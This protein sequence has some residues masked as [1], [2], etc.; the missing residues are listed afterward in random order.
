MLLVFPAENPPPECQYCKAR[1]GYGIEMRKRLEE[2]G[3]GTEPCLPELNSEPAE[4]I[5]IA[6][7]VEG[8][9]DECLMPVGAVGCI[10]EG[11]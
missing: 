4:V 11:V 8:E 2:L 10:L 1:E 5:I 9:E 7:F 3:W 6:G